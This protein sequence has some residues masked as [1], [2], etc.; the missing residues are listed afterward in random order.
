MTTG[1]PYRFYVVAENYVGLSSA[2]SDI[3]THWVCHAPSGLE[4]PTRVS[5]TSTSVDLA[6]SPPSDDGGCA[7]TGYAILFGDEK[8]ASPT[9]EIPYTE[10]HAVQ[11][12]DNPNLS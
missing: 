2:P 11:V 9:G 10:V 5:T 4:P 3:S 1:N 8:D 12:R 7:V 6:W